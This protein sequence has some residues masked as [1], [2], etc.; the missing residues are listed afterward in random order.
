M[1]A[2]HCKRQAEHYRPLAR[3]MTDLTEK[4]TFFGLATYWARL[5]KEAEHGAK[6]KKKPARLKMPATGPSVSRNVSAQTRF[7]NRAKNENEKA[8]SW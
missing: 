6:E 3:Q 5:A 2:D 8:A 4:A 1:D 7:P